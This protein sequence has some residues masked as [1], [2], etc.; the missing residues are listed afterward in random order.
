MPGAYARTA[1]QALTNVIYRYLE[2]LADYGVDEACQKNPALIGGINI[3][4]GR[5]IHKVVAEA[6]GI[7]LAED[8]IAWSE[9][10]GTVAIWLERICPPSAELRRRI[11]FSAD[12]RHHSGEGF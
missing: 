10:N 1:T 4:D 7:P 12:D 8:K 6:H 2:T 3:K 5:I 9:L 11:T